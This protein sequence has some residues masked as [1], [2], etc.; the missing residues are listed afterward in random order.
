MNTYAQS[1]IRRA[2]R[3][4]GLLLA[5]T[6]TVA[7][8]GIA[9]PRAEPAR[10]FDIPLTNVAKIVVGDDHACALL[11]DHTLK[12]WGSNDHNVLAQPFG[13]NGTYSSDIPLNVPGLGG[14]VFNVA[15]GNTS[16]C[17][18][19]SDFSV[20]CWG[21]TLYR[22]GLGETPYWFVDSET[23]VQIGGL[24]GAD[25]VLDVS[26]G[27]YHACAL[28]PGQPFNGGVCWGDN[29]Y[30]QLGNSTIPQQ[31]DPFYV[32]RP[33]ASVEFGALNPVEISAGSYHTCAR[34]DPGVVSC[35]G[36]GGNGRIG[37]GHNATRFAPEFVDGL[38]GAVIDISAGDNHTCAVLSDGRVQCWGFNGNGELGNNSLSD[39]NV[40]TLAVIVLASKVSAGAHHTCALTRQYTVLCWGA[41]GEGQLGDGTRNRSLTPQLVPGLENV[42]AIDAGGKQTCALLFDTSVKCWGDGVLTPTDVVASRI[43]VDNTVPID[44]GDVLNDVPGG[45]SQ[46][47][48]PYEAGDAPGGTASGQDIAAY[49][50]V[51]GRF[52]SLD[53]GGIY[54]PKHANPLRYFL[55]DA[56]SLDAP[57]DADGVPN[58]D[59]VNRVANLDASD[60]GWLNGRD[61]AR[62]D[63]CQTVTLRVRIR[64]GAVVTST[65]PLYLNAWFDGNRDG[66]WQDSRGCETGSISHEWIVQNHK[67]PDRLQP[68]AGGYVDI[69]VTTQ[70]VASNSPV[71]PAWMRISLSDRPAITPTNPAG[72]L[73]DGRGMVGLFGYGETEDYL[74]DPV[75]PR[76]QYGDW[77]IRKT[78][79]NAGPFDVGS[80]LDYVIEV[81]RTGGSTANVSAALVDVL[82]QQ[83]SFVSGVA[84]NEVSPTANPASA[85]FEAG[86]G[87]PNGRVRW[88]GTLSAG[89]HFRLRFQA[90][91]DA[92]TAAPVNNTAYLILPGPGQVLSTTL[93]TPLNCTPP[94]PP[95]FALSKQMVDAI[96]STSPPVTQQISETVYLLTLTQ[97][98]AISNL[99]AA[100]QDGLPP[101][102]RA[103]EVSASRG[104]ITTTKNGRTVSWLG[105]VGPSLAPAQVWIRAQVSGPSQCGRDLVNT[106]QYAV[107]MPD[108]TLSHGAS[109]PVTFRP[110][111]TPPPTATPRPT[112]VPT[113]R[114]TYTPVPVATNTSV[115]LPT[116][117]PPNS[118]TYTPVPRAT[119]TSVPLPR[120]TNTP[121][122]I[123]TNTPVPLP[124]DAPPN[125]PT[126]TPVPRPTNTSVPVEP[127]GG[128]PVQVLLPIVSR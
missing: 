92:C 109:G 64:R 36:Y 65:A 29:Y 77:E 44:L 106:A 127:S 104:A 96:G 32:N 40:A 87:G 51:P 121:V 61:I 53:N 50:G 88:T 38:N 18:M 80:T 13:N 73:P 82:P 115:P 86:Y 117:A 28:I 42:A 113:Q 1:F 59:T 11:T 7:G 57:V 116:D 105:A 93:A 66:D 124:T 31:P 69:D 58:I 16:N 112:E 22:V 3:A 67:I 128:L 54:G 68:A 26:A 120:L 90:R 78:L 94:P 47:Q 79:V 122:P 46:Q 19:L 63:D 110:G 84:F 76:E 81:R 9:L 55:G 91:V 5:V 71:N 10:A 39:S 23:P 21:N 111:C 48:V 17:V 4:I 49:P 89:G 95:S 100:I 41:N 34:G 101:G 45:P 37:D 12:C 43:E 35:W 8:I 85:V 99:A 119:N 62:F 97:S 126:N 25:D 30:G 103:V 114:P 74:W 2:R 102:L 56:T 98:H 27:L 15:A 75:T 107:R 60:D 72:A 123:Q 108:G 24:D 14:D 83:T 33:R 20:K 125:S 70:P 52:P 118:P 6:L